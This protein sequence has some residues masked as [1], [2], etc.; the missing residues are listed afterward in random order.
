MSPQ[1]WPALNSSRQASRMAGITGTI[2]GIAATAEASAAI[3]P[4]RPA[5]A[6]LFDLAGCGMLWHR[7]ASARGQGA[8]LIVCSHHNVSAGDFYMRRSLLL[9]GATAAVLAA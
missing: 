2:C 5:Q 9:A 4:G 3:E 8:A 1:A 7:T 6:G